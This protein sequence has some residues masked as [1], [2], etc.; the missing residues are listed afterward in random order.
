MTVA[1]TAAEIGYGLLAPLVVRLRTAEGALLAIIAS[2]LWLEH[3]RPWAAILQ[4]VLCTLVMAQMYAHNDI[5]DARADLDNPRKGVRL[6]TLL[7]THEVFFRRASTAAAL[8]LTLVMGLTVD[9]RTASSAVAVMALNS[10]YSRWL[11]SVPIVDVV[12]VGIWGGLFA[13]LVTRRVGLLVGVALMTAISHVFQTLL[14]RHA[15]QR[16]AI[17]T[18]GTRAIG[19]SLAVIATLSVALGMWALPRAGGFAASLVVAPV[20]AVVL[21]P[22]AGPA[23]LVAKC[24]FAAIWMTVLA[25]LEW[26]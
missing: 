5:V 6:A 26:G 22:R 13:G 3:A 1:P 7:V 14:D 19:L 16:A 17:S 4:F 24:A 8:V 15:D 25:R 10:A 18:T 11:K 2:L 20:A 12:T 23:W 9:G 21:M